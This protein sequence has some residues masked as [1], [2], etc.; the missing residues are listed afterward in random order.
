MDD[1]KLTFDEIQ[2][3]V[4]HYDIFKYDGSGVV[5][6]GIFVRLTD[7]HLK[8]IRYENEIDNYLVYQREGMVQFKL[9]IKGEG[10]WLALLNPDQLIDIELIHALFD[11]NIE[12]ISSNRDHRLKERRRSWTINNIL[13]HE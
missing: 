7:K 11:R 12:V 3:F 5:F 9:G 10:G 6:N 4:N 13:T 2:D 1:V 8:I